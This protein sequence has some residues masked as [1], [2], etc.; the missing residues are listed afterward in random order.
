MLHRAYFSPGMF[1]FGRLASYDYFVHLERA[2]AARIREKG[3]TL[4]TYV[5]DVPPTASIRKRAGRLMELVARTC[6]DDEDREGPIH[7]VGHSTG[8][9]DARLVASPSARLPAPAEAC[10]WLPRL[11]SVS[12]LSTPHYGTPLASFFATVSGQRVLHALSALTF[13]ALSVGAPPMAAASALVVAVGRLDRAVGLDIRLLDRATDALLRI[14]D[15]ARSREV[16]AYLDAIKEDQGAIV[17]VMPEAMDLF[18]AGIEDRPGVYYQ[19]AAAMAP[20]PRPMVW[21]REG[22][23]APWSALS[24]PVFA[25][26]YGVTSRADERYPCAASP[27]EP[28]A[29]ALLRRSFDELPGFRDNDGVVPIRSQIWGELVWTGYGDHLD[30]LGHFRDTRPRP[31]RLETPRERAEP[32]HVDWL[33]SG[34]GF[35]VKSFAALTQALAD[36]MHRAANRPEPVR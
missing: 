29:E 3:D 1:G 26:L 17:Q 35:D 19:S 24:T 34:S 32:M 9:L 14:L 31:K 30:V 25:M 36:G 6:E 10:Q 12:T 27:V 18:Q 20:S 23:S 15:D 7:L 22:L 21:L 33:T 4:Q 5:V 11:A 8:G 13:I 28:Q 2:L 16:R